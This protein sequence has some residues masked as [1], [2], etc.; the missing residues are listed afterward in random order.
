MS[1]R[2]ASGASKICDAKR[3]VQ[4][5]VGPSIRSSARHCRSGSGSASVPKSLSVPAASEMPK[6]SSARAAARP[7]VRAAN[8]PGY[9]TDRRS[10]FCRHAPLCAPGGLFAGRV[11]ALA[12]RLHSRS[13][14][15]SRS[16]A[17]ATS[18]AYLEYGVGRARRGPDRRESAQVGIHDRADCVGR[19]QTAECRRSRSR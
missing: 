16:R 18:R 10:D 5:A 6:T 11:G 8:P 7:A 1:T 19:G 3:A 2:T 9:W 14:Q 15:R 12:D 4:C 17:C 13:G